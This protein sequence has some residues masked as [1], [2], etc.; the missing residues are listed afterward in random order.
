MR[1]TVLVAEGDPFDL[2]VLQEACEGLGQEVLSAMRAEQVLDMLARQ[3]PDL[4]MLDVGVPI[5]G[6]DVLRVLR[7]D[8]RLEQF[9]VILVTSAESAALCEEGMKLG[10]VDYI[11]KPYRVFEIQQRVQNVLRRHRTGNA[12]FPPA[13]H[14]TIADE[15][16]KTGTIQQLRI[17]VNYEYTRAM[18]YG[19]PLT[20]M[21]VG[22]SNLAQIVEKNGVQAADEAMV[23]VAEALR[24]AIRDV[25]QL[26]R[27]D[28]DEFTVLLPETDR[29]GAAIVRDRLESLVAGDGFCKS[30]LNPVPDL[31]I[32]VASHP[33]AR[34]KRPSLLLMAA[35]EDAYGKARSSIVPTQ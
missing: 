1:S 35:S 24:G 11:I 31:K 33:N 18:R 10:A 22:L 5:R 15:L 23:A 14:T 17:S 25:D 3:Q 2:R 30:A 8:H 7:E 6:L 28:I 27:S 26:Y 4:L 16:T 13:V 12:I 9:P 20:C 29:R 19:H 34:T 21:V 32:G